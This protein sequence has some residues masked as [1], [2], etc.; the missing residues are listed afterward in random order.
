MHGRMFRSWKRYVVVYTYDGKVWMR[1]N[2][3]EW[4]VFTAYAMEVI[5]FYFR[6]K[7]VRVKDLKAPQKC[8]K[9][10]MS[11]TKSYK[12]QALCSC[13]LRREKMRDEQHVQ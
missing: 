13:C 7:S 1:R 6:N 4:L 9:C 11:A 5:M 12:G 3:S 8:H 10:V 2:V